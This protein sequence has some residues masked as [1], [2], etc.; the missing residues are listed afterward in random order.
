MKIENWGV[1][2]ERPDMSTYEIVL[3]EE[4]SDKV[5][6]YI[7]KLKE[8]DMYTDHEATG[9]ILSGDTKGKILW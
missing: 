8:D 9:G 4:L 1:F 2:V 5:W 3:N 6:D 7:K